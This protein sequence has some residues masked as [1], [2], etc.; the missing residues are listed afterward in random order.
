MSDNLNRIPHTILR[1]GAY[2]IRL[3][4]D[5]LVDPDQ[6]VTPSPSVHRY[7][8]DVFRQTMAEKGLPLDL[9]RTT[10]VLSHDEDASRA[11]VGFKVYVWTFTFP[12]PLFHPTLT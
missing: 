2:N 5:L 11:A 4:L 7:A 1:K 6:E 9:A 12:V 3:T 8:I 10:I